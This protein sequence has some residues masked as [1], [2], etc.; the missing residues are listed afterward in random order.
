MEA[1]QSVSMAHAQCTVHCTLE[2]MELGLCGCWQQLLEEL[3]ED[4]EEVEEDG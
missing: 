2:Q 3:Q 4:E 1:K